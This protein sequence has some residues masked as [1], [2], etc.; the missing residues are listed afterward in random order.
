M[1]VVPIVNDNTVPLAA[2]IIEM[3]ACIQVSVHSADDFV[4]QVLIVLFRV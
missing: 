1:V 2:K 3:D 4:T